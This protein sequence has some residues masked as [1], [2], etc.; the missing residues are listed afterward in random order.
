M[1]E[2][3]NSDLTEL[4]V[5]EHALFN[6]D[7]SNLLLRTDGLFHANNPKGDVQ[8]AEHKESITPPPPLGL[9]AAQLVDAVYDYHAGQTVYG[10][11]EPPLQFRP[12]RRT[13][14][15][16][17]LQ[18]APII[19]DDGVGGATAA[20]VENDGR[21][22]LMRLG[23]SPPPKQLAGAFPADLGR[24]SLDLHS[25][26]L[27]ID[28]LPS[29]PAPSHYEESEVSMDS[30]EPI[31]QNSRV[32]ISPSSSSG[33]IVQS[34]L[35]LTI[36]PSPSTYFASQ[37]LVNLVPYSAAYRD[38]VGAEIRGQR[39]GIKLQDAVQSA[40]GRNGDGSIESK[41]SCAGLWSIKDA[42]RAAAA[43]PGENS[44]DENA[45]D[46]DNAGQPGAVSVPRP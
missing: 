39:P 25:L 10:T 26:L 29:S 45:V 20:L 33:M 32:A 22:F 43:R 30:N 40:T 37:S 16:S 3:R 2:T 18:P 34:Q 11:L 5:R 7:A 4:K 1:T 19:N 38:H 27:P 9:P 35:R 24:L 13:I 15:S 12:R 8:T 28:E 46:T 41:S 17:L 6:N 14:I 36:E 21:S 23:S 31:D 42:R 44:G